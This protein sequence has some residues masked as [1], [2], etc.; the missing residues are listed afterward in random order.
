[1]IDNLRKEHFDLGK[2]RT[3]YA[4]ANAIIGAGSKSA[5]K[6]EDPPWAHLRTNFEVGTDADPKSTDY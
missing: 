2:Q 1:M 5:R 3:H 4:R 6:R